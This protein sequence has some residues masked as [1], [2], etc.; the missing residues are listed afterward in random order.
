MSATTENKMS[1]TALEQAIHAAFTPGPVLNPHWV[2]LNYSRGEGTGT[3]PAS[4]IDHIEVPEEVDEDEYAD[5]PALVDVCAAIPAPPPPPPT[6]P[7]CGSRAREL[8][9]AWQKRE[10]VLESQR[11]NE[12]IYAEVERIFAKTTDTAYKALLDKIATVEGKS[13]IRVTLATHFT[14]VINGGI[15]YR[16]RPYTDVE[17]E[18]HPTL[19]GYLEKYGHETM[20][21][22]GIELDY[23]VRKTDFLDRLAA[24]F[25][26]A[27][28]KCRRIVKHR[29]T[30]HAGEFST[31]TVDIV[32]EYWPYGVRR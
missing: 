17:G 27:N 23:L 3:L 21:S 6:E 12:P 1:A 32:L 7:W 29:V 8:L 25:G 24:K 16:T 15:N 28:F 14:A 4:P 9:K 11:Y 13:E 2:G 18:I 31:N 30:D 19:Y 26:E 22:H 20:T 5:M 10:R